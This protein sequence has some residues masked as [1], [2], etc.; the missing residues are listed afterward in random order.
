MHD[1]RRG[2]SRYMRVAMGGAECDVLAWAGDDLDDGL[3]QLR[4]LPLKVLEEG[5]VVAA[6]VYERMGDASVGES[7]EEY[8]RGRVHRG[9][10]ASVRCAGVVAGHEY[11]DGDKMR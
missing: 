4:T 8:R 3:P 2:L 9:R 5:G 7:L 10:R 11:L 6:P 1:D